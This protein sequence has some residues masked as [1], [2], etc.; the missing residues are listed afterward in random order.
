MMLIRPSSKMNRSSLKIV[1][2]AFLLVQLIGVGALD[3]YSG[4]ELA[5]FPLYAIPVA[6]SVWYFNSAT[7][8]V[9]SLLCATLSFWADISAGQIY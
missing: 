8:I 5:I 3:Y 1:P 2:V 4:F 6:F 9:V 7:G